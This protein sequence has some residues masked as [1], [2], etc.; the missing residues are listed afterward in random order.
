MSRRFKPPWTAERA[1]GGYVVKDARLHKVRIT[2]D[3]NS[4]RPLLNTC[5]VPAQFH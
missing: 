5:H 3:S 1:T 4:V 2:R